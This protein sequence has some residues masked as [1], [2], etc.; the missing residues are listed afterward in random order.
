MR[1][2]VLGATGQLGREIVGTLAKRGHRVCA[3]VRRPPQPPLDSSAEVRLADARNKEQ[4]RSAIGGCD[5]VVNVIG[6]G[7]LRRNEVASS[8]TAVVVPAVQAAGVK[9]YVAMSAGMVALDWPFFK[10]VIRPLVFR[11]ILAEHKRVETI[12]TASP[13]DWTIV[14]PTAL[15]NH[16]AK[17]YVA[18]LE[19]QRRA[20]ITT[21][22]DVAAFIADELE[23]NKYERKAVFIA[24]RG[25]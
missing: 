6:G 22:A 13:L 8:A 5:A 4:I 17:G 2:A 24:S 9:R 16:P 12:V 20:F 15:T 18:S 11:H 10:Y 14:R 21:R 19:L 7:T 25:S 1:I 3:V 23:G